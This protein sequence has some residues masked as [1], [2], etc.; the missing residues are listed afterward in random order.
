MIPE[1]PERAGVGYTVDPYDTPE[2]RAECEDA[3]TSLFAFTGKHGTF[4]TWRERHISI[5]AFK[6]GLKAG[7]LEQVPECPPMFLD[8]QQY[9]DGVAMGANVGKIVSYSVAATITTILGIITTYLALKQ[10]GVI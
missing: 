5:L 8:E 4:S 7:S 2:E 1:Y 6:A 10:T 3:I 9:W